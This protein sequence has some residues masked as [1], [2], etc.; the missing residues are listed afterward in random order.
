[1]MKEK[2]NV[3]RYNNNLYESDFSTKLTS[4]NLHNEV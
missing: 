3:D 1:M 4:K 2:Y